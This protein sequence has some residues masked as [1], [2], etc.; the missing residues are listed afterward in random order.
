MELLTLHQNGLR[1]TL[2]I[3][4]NKYPPKMYPKANWVLFVVF[5]KDLNLFL[6]Y[7]MTRSKPQTL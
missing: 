7:V 6:I 1:A 4:N 5:P 3:E 2:V